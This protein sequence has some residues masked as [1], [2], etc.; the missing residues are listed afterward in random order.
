MR[1]DKIFLPGNV[2]FYS[3]S[4]RGWK[5]FSSHQLHFTFSRKAALE[6]HVLTKFFP[7]TFVSTRPRNVGGNSSPLISCT[8]LSLRKAALEPH[9]LT[10]FFFR[11]TNEPVE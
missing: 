7:V 4:T 10:N 11:V 5:L 9:V 8:S 1:V 3:T 2:R 6:P